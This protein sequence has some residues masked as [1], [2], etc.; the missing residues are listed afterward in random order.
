MLESLSH[1]MELSFHWQHANQPRVLCCKCSLPIRVALCSSRLIAVGSFFTSTKHSSNMYSFLSTSHWAYMA[2]AM[3]LAINRVS[4]PFTIK[5]FHIIQACIQNWVVWTDTHG[6][7]ITILLVC[8]H[9]ALHNLTYTGKH[10]RCMH[11]LITY[12][13]H[14][15]LVQVWEHYSVLIFIEVRWALRGIRHTYIFKFTICKLHLSIPQKFPWRNAYHTISVDPP[16][17]Q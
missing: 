14:D 10:H 16:F 13:R 8:T 1:D 7:T 4:S 11:I 15:L 12:F 5:E 3:A 2:G 6:V 9:W 17:A